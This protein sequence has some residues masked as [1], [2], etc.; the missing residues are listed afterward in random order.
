M[1]ISKYKSL[2]IQEAREHLSGIE[3][4]LASLEKDPGGSGGGAAE[5][6]RIVDSLFRHYH[7][8]KGMSASM[9]YEPIQRFS[10]AQ[11]DLLDRVRSG[12]LAITREITSLL[13]QC[14]DE[15][16]ALVD[17]VEADA[18]LDLDIEPSLRMIREA[19]SPD[20]EAAPKPEAK[21]VPEPAAEGP[22]A[23]DPGAREGAEESA[24]T[25]APPAMSPPPA[26]SA[27]PAMSAAPSQRGPELK[28]SDVMKVEGAVF[29]DLLAGIGELFMAL[30]SL[31]SLSA[32]SRSIALK[33]NVYLLGK[34]VNKLHGGILSA[35]MLPLSDLTEGLPRVVRDI[36]RKSGK[37]VD[38][39]LDG[40][41]L[42]LDRSVL[43]DLGAPLVHIIR[44]AVDHGIESV[45]E[46]NRAGKP[47]RGS[48]TI[49]ASPRKDH[50]ILT[51]SDDGRGIDVEKI[52][53]KAV[54]R[55]MDPGEVG[56]LSDP[57]ALLLICLP[58]LTSAERVT[59]TSGRGVGM[60]VVK[61]KI[62]SLGGYVEIRTEAGKG[63]SC[64]VVIPITLAIIKAVLVRVGREMMAIPL[65]AAA[66]TLA[67]DADRIQRIEGREVMELRGEMLPIIRLDR[68]FSLPRDGEIGRGFVVVNGYGAR[69]VGFFV[70]DVLG[71]QEVVIKSLGRHLEG[72]RGIAGAAEVGRHRVVL[73][74]DAESLVEESLGRS[75]RPRAEAR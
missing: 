28:L 71:Q 15:L 48:I 36:S 19:G 60:D 2:Y 1:D 52:K 70:D 4:G 42:R 25:E 49:K 45:E 63:T 67:L 31:K 72:V 23:E 41:D 12:R 30:S 55:G 64:T 68:I 17:R 29:D 40:T 32:E 11:E 74:L 16:S 14:L 5:T 38:L 44:N 18:P 20:A 69:R 26:V 9:G 24:A 47:P 73:V 7:T 34:T 75:G 46:R 8:I 62:A 54:E 13:F 35:R 3:S 39:S 51:V 22:A 50:V 66:E 56:G 53:K 33:E 27:T 65:A 61:E 59:E 37:E 6:G 10:H 58:G 43:E 21:G 57:E